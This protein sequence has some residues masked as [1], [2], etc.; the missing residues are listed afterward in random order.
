MIPQHIKVTG[1]LNLT[2]DSFSDGGKY[3]TI[4]A[5]I[6]QAKKLVAEGADIID[7]G[8]ESSRPGA[9]LVSLE[10][11]LNRVLPTVKRLRELSV[12]ISIDTYKPEVAEACLQEGVSIVN[13]ISGLRNPVMMDVIGKYNVPV[14][15]MHMPGTPQT[16]QQ[17][18]YSGDI[19]MEV[20]E[21]L[22]TRIEEAHARGIT[23]IIVD[24]G[25]GFGKNPEQNYEILLR[26]EEFKELNCP[27]L[28]GPS[29]KSFQGERKLNT[30][31][32]IVLGVKN[33]AD[34]VRVHDVAAVKRYLT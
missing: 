13:D 4:E 14:I 23:R 24:P 9:K 34:I 3:T 8:G 31:E 21:Y 20:K 5:A 2:P 16:M 17:Y 1:I 26:L 27:I 10:E 18:V 7:V 30:L 25:L 33:G 32:A 12:P 22:R 11:E 28:I 29:R 19:V 6:E 15:I